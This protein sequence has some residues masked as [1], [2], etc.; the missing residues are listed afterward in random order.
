MTVVSCIH[1]TTLLFRSNQSLQRRCSG[2]TLGILYLSRHGRGWSYSALMHVPQQQLR[3]IGFLNSPKCG[4]GRKIV[5]SWC[6]AT[7]T[8]QQQKPIMMHMLHQSVRVHF[9]LSHCNPPSSLLSPVRLLSKKH[10]TQGEIGQLWGCCRHG[11]AG[12]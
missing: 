2:D 7:S 3:D 8:P 1:Y 6:F 10:S 12:S 9:I 11:G 5:A 4:L